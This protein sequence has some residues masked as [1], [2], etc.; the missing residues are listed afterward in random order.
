MKTD[1]RY[2]LLDPTA[3]TL[4]AGRYAASG[5][6]SCD[7][8]NCAERAKHEEIWSTNLKRRLD[9]WKECGG[10]L[11][12][13]PGSTCL[14]QQ[15]GAGVSS[16]VCEQLLQF[17]P[18]FICRKTLPASAFLIDNQRSALQPGSVRSAKKYY[19]CDSVRTLII[20]ASM[21]KKLG[22]GERIDL[23]FFGPK[24]AAYSPSSICLPVVLRPMPVGLAS[25]DTD[26]PCRCRRGIIIISLSVMEAER[27]QPIGGRLREPGSP[28]NNVHM[29]EG[30]VTVT[31][32]E[33]PPRRASHDS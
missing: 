7:S 24:T 17:R 31:S 3:K 9:L 12:P 20:P 27:L 10:W 28:P 26:R 32:R 2:S 29:V 13:M 4:S 21:M 19:Y 5:V 30:V 18:R 33:M 15:C 16:M 22:G 14:S 23:G 8:R 25:S 6:G 1:T 11:C